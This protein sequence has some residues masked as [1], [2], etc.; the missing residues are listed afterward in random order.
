MQGSKSEW[1]GIPVAES[2]RFKKSFHVIDIDPIFTTFT[3]LKLPTFRLMCSGR[4]RHHFQYNLSISCFLED[5]D[6]I[7]KIF[8]KYSADF[9]EVADL[10][11]SSMFK[12]VDLQDVEISP[13]N[14]SRK[15]F[16]IFLELS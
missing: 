5:I 13:N 9:Q 6:P 12:V 2:N 16:G 4:Y 1:G 14:I 8:K 10:A 15:L 11:C 7:F 3:Q